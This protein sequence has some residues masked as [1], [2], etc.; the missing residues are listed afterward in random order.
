MLTVR[1]PLTKALAASSSPSPSLRPKLT[2]DQAAR[3]PRPNPK[4][5]RDRSNWRPLLPLSLKRAADMVVRLAHPQLPP[6]RQFPS[7][8]E[9]LRALKCSFFSGKKEHTA[10]CASSKDPDPFIQFGLTF[11]TVPPRILCRTRSPSVLASGS[12]KGNQEYGTQE[13]VTASARS[14]LLVQDAGRH[15]L[16]EKASELY[17][18]ESAPMGRAWSK[19]GVQK[20]SSLCA[21]TFEAFGVEIRR[22]A[23]CGFCHS[24]SIFSRV[25]GSGSI[26]T[27]LR[28]ATS[29]CSLA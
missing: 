23:R 19:I 16:V 9:R 1:L 4:G 27:L 20:G 11:R 21:E 10:S 6:S 2:V 15:C 17:L 25:V 3:S 24:G 7:S 29:S 18:Q 28:E 12:Q 22:P 5:S 14:F 13:Y 26:K 8:H